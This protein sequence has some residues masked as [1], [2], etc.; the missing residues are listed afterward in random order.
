M[1]LADTNVVST[2]ARV[3]AIDLLRRLCRSDRLHV[4][5]ATFNELRRAVE[6]GCGFLVPTLE[7]IQTG[8]GLDLVE[9]RRDEILALQ[10]LPHSLGAGEAESIAVCLHRPGTRLLTNDKRARNF[11]R[12]HSIPC[13]DLPAI[14][15]GLWMRQVAT[16]E[17]VRQLVRRIETE[18]GMVIGT[19]TRSSSDWGT[20]DT[21]CR[22]LAVVD[23]RVVRWRRPWGAVRP[24]SK[25]AGPLANAQAARF[26][27]SRPGHRALLERRE[28]FKRLRAVEFG[29]PAAPRRLVLQQR[30]A[31]VKRG[32]D[33]AATG[34][35]SYRRS[36][37]AGW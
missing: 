35:C 30:Q 2:F 36:R 9:L 24:A 4:T 16:K 28:L 22:R 10:D 6:V 13:L 29:V 3:E 23:Q 14:L 21:G 5:P 31:V 27:R 7:A 18:Q 32:L 37:S 19:R 25:P 12:E 8:S 26:T 11:C 33:P 15:R 34:S 17:R 20:S 1:I